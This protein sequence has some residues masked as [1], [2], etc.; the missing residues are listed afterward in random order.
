M[1]EAGFVSLLIRFH[2]FFLVLPLC[3]LRGP[4]FDFVAEEI[5]R[6]CRVGAGFTVSQFLV[7]GAFRIGHSSM[8]MR[9]LRKVASGEPRGEPRLYNEVC[10]RGIGSVFVRDYQGLR[11]FLFSAISC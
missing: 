1:R 8:I 11:P 4:R 6:P 7:D 9:K 10:H 5:R 3:L 2:F